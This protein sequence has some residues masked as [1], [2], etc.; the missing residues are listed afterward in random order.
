MKDKDMEQWTGRF[1]LLNKRKPTRL[2]R[3]SFIVGFD[4]GIHYQI[5]FVNQ[6]NDEE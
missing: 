3:M 6:E 2:E 1:K 4:A 5:N